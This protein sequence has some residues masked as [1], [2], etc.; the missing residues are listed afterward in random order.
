MDTNRLI[1]AWMAGATALVASGQAAYAGCTVDNASATD[2]SATSIVVAPNVGTSSLTVDGVST[3]GLFYS[4]PNGAS[5][6]T[7]TQTL[8]ITGATTISNPA[9]QNYVNDGVGVSMV[10]VGPNGV[11]GVVLNASATIGSSVVVNSRAEY[12]GAVFLRTE[13][14]GNLSINNAGTVTALGVDGGN[15]QLSNATVIGGSWVDGL[16]AVTAQGSSTIVNS[17]SVTAYSGRGIYA[18]GNTTAVVLD[19]NENI[20]T[21]NA[22]AV[23]VSIDNAAAGHVDA[24]LAGI[25]VINYY[26]L[27]QATNEGVVHSSERQAIIGWS[28]AGDTSVT[29]SG[30]A[31]SDDLN[32]VVAE[33][34][35]GNATIVNSGVATAGKLASGSQGAAAGYAGLRAYA[36]FTGDVSIT[37]AATGVVTANYDAAIIAQTPQ[38]DATVVNHGKVSGLNGVFIDNGSGLGPDTLVDTSAP[39]EAPLAGTAQLTNDGVITAVQ[40]GVYLNGA[41]NLL[42][43]SGTIAASS[44][45]AVL[46]GPGGTGQITNSGTITGGVGVIVARSIAIDNSGLIHGATVGVDVVDSQGATGSAASLSN[47]GTISGGAKAIVVGAGGRLAAISNTG[48]ISG[49]VAIDTTGAGAAVAITQAGGSITGAINLSSTFADHLAVTGGTISGPING[50]AATVDFGSAANPDQSYTLNDAVNV[51]AVNILGGR[52]ILAHD[53]TVAHAL[54]NNASLEVDTVRTVTGDYAQSAGATLVIG[55]NNDNGSAGKLVV[56][57]N[58][59]IAAGGLITVRELGSTVTDAAQTYTIV[60]AGGSGVYTGAALSSAQIANPYLPLSAALSTSG[61]DLILTLTPVVP[62]DNTGPTTPG[63]QQVDAAVTSNSHN[64]AAALT[65]LYQ[66]NGLGSGSV[67]VLAA[68]NDFF[69]NTASP[70][71]AAQK[72]QIVTTQ[73][74]PSN[75]VVDTGVTQ[76]FSSASTTAVVQH[77]QTARARDGDNGVL[78]TGLVAP[79][80]EVWAQAIGFTARRATSGDTEG[81]RAT[82]GGFALG[83]DTLVRPGVKL[84]ATFAYAETWADG[85]DLASGNSTRIQSYQVG[86]YGSYDAGSW[87]ANAQVAVGFDRYDQNRTLTFMNGAAQASYSGLDTTVHVD[88]GKDFH[89]GATQLTPIAAVTYLHQNIDGYTESLT[90]ER[91]SKV[92]VDTVQ[93]DLGLQASWMIPMGGV[94]VQPTVKAGWLHD[95]VRGPIAVNANLGG[96]SFA[97]YAERPSADGADLGVAVT[98]YDIGAWQFQAQYDGNF[99]RDYASN[100]FLVNMKMHF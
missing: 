63:Q 41:A 22:P 75:A 80:N 61:N 36:D 71:T 89:L 33:T 43:N 60:S 18:E 82:S 21:V 34:E 76:A 84:G 86:A 67:P 47:S 98:V 64:V 4:P 85:L 78:C 57:R 8:N 31:T 88:L 19:G 16:N 11:A 10:S 17:G 1:V 45:T 66:I 49:P 35:R 25:R 72:I 26:G 55:V 9:G 23:T 20:L 59:T 97:T 96:I 3:V 37:N 69:N 28:P 73:L 53:I 15:V 38:G 27:A 51:G 62:F 94:R 7:F 46:V 39:G 90:D 95:W 91:M 13:F 52:V 40:N 65:K 93:T 81:D 32:A 5:A 99:S 100:T 79:Q 30:T 74:A 87:Y 6:S 24:Y 54:T 2:C 14:A 29:N 48:V 44:G 42:N 58:A 70:L 50:S 92:G 56:T 12:G 68:I 83:A 77:L